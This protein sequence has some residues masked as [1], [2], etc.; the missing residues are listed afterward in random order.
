MV[1][2]PESD[3]CSL[4]MR[5]NKQQG[6]VR[7][8]MKTVRSRENATPRSKLGARCGQRHKGDT[9]DNAEQQKFGDLAISK[10]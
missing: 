6:Q 8:Q 2:V 9:H 5:A 3:V 10:A 4:A 7:Y 1:A